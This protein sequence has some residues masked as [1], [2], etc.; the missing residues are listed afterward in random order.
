MSRTVEIPLDLLEE[1]AQ[2][3][4]PLSTQEALSRLMDKNSEGQ[5][6]PEERGELQALVELNERVSVLKGRARLLLGKHRQ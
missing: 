4:L 6:T 3:E 1:F 2:L 5:L